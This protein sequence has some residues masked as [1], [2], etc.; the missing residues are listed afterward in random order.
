MNKNFFIWSLIIVLGLLFSFQLVSG[1]ETNIMSISDCVDVKISIINTSLPITEGEY[2]FK[3]CEQNNNTWS[4]ICQDDYILTLITNLTTINTY[5]F[6]INYTTKYFTQSTRGSSNGG[7][8]RILNITPAINITEPLTNLTN[9]TNEWINV[10]PNP[11]IT[12]IEN[13]TP[14]IQI[15]LKDEPE[16]PSVTASVSSWKIILIS[17]IGI[18]ILSFIIMLI[19]NFWPPKKTKPL[20]FQSQPKFDP[21]WKQ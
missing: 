19:I 15:P 8:F 3:N 6:E 13:K 16:P 7:N 1:L 9:N 11:I 2:S 17:I 10:T 5:E 4:C 21:R 18:I 14:P 20:T 12:P